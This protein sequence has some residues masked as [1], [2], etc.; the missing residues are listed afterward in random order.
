MSGPTSEALFLKA[1]DSF[2]ASLSPSEKQHLSGCKSI[3][4]VVDGIRK[5][6]HVNRAKRRTLPCLARVKSFGDQLRPYFDIL[7]R[8][9]DALPDWAN[10]ALGA[11]QLVLQ[12]ASHFVTFFEKLCITIE[13]IGSRLPRYQE[14]YDALC[15]TPSAISQ[16]LKSS[17]QKIY[18]SLFEFLTA[19]ARVFSTRDGKIK[20]SPRIVASLVWKPFELRFQK[21]LDEIALHKE[22]VRE[23]LQ[24]ASAGALRTVLMQDRQ[25]ARQRHAKLAEELEEQ[26]AR[27]DEQALRTFTASLN[28]WIDPPEYK[29]IV[30]DAFQEKIEGTAEW[31]FDTDIFASWREYEYEPGMHSPDALSP[32]IP[33]T[34]LWV[35]GEHYMPSHYSPDGSDTDDPQGKPGSGKTVLAASTI[36]ELGRPAVGD[37][38]FPP[39]VCY[40]FFNKNSSTRNSPVDAYRALAAQIFHRFHKLEKIHNVFA[41]AVSENMTSLTKASE[42]ELVDV[43]VQCLPHLPMLYFV[44]DGI[45]ECTDSRKLVAYVSDWC[46]A[47][48]LKVLFFSRPDVPS[49]LRA[50]PE[51]NRICLTGQHLDNDIARYL[52]LVMD[53]MIWQRLL[54]ANADRDQLIQNLVDRAEGMFLWVRLMVVFLNG[55]VM[56]KAERLETIMEAKAESLDQ[57][58]A[59][60]CRIRTRIDRLDARSKNLAYKA[61][62][63]TAYEVFS[64]HEL[65]EGICQDG[66]DMDDGA[67]TEQF[68]QMIILICC[69]LIEK[70]LNGRYKYIH[71]TALQF[72]LTGSPRQASISPLV[73][74]QVTS[75]ALMATRYVSF[76]ALQVPRKPLAGRI[77]QNAKAESVQERWPLLRFAAYRWI[78]FALDSIQ[79]LPEVSTIDEVD[80][81]ISTVSPYLKEGLGIMV[82]VEALYTLLGVNLRSTFQ[83]SRVKAI[84][85]LGSPCHPRVESF[86]SELQELL[87]DMINLDQAWG[88]T[89][90]Q[91]PSEIWGDVTVFTKSKFLVTTSAAMQESL[92]PRLEQAVDSPFTEPTKPIFSVAMSSSDASKL[93]VLSI[94][95]S[96]AFR[97]GWEN[98]TTIPCTQ[99][100]LKKQ[101][102]GK[103]RDSI[104]CGFSVLGGDPSPDIANA[105]LGWQATYELFLVQ[106]TASHSVHLVTISLDPMDVEICLRQNLRYT[107]LR[108]WKCT[109]PLSIAP[110][111]GH[112]SIL[113]R[114]VSFHSNRATYSSTNLPLNFD[115]R[116]RKAWSLDMNM[117][118]RYTYDVFWSADS[119]YLAFI[120]DNRLTAVSLAIFS[121]PTAGGAADPVSI[122]HVSAQSS[123]SGLISDCQFHPQEQLFLFRR[124][125]NV[126]LWHFSE[127]HSFPKLVHNLPPAPPR[128]DNDG[129]EICRSSNEYRVS[130]SHCGM[131][132]AIFNHGRPWPT[133]MPLS[134]FH[135]PACSPRKRMAI[136]AV[137]EQNEPRKRAILAR[138]QEGTHE[139]SLEQ[140]RMPPVISS[141]AVVCRTDDSTGASITILATKEMP[142]ELSLMRRDEEHEVNISVAKLPS[143]IPMGPVTATV[144]LPSSL[145]QSEGLGS[146]N[147]KVILAQKSALVYESD[148]APASTYLPLIIRKDARTLTITSSLDQGRE[149][150]KSMSPALSLP[151]R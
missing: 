115:P 147:C 39:E 113:S 58:D 88:I 62:M 16:E 72:A 74:P 77:G 42:N 110:D 136:E 143:Y 25:R 125:T 24:F 12:L 53:D 28:Q 93:A 55:P 73:P 126:Y 80:Q 31:L 104:E 151:Y 79:Q 17:L 99:E 135:S 142:G 108:R 101:K 69:G 81:M 114:I 122:N 144:S 107:P 120:D 26:H 118:S 82:W 7:E 109:F 102:A 30:E 71:L 134:D 49:L 127:D 149:N 47:S 34:L 64:S 54:P 98:N 18:C 123:W 70:G 65:R 97:L 128:L 11:L 117:S 133:L 19:V 13:S 20:R 112:C 87:A 27:N 89:L 56:T 1:R 150:I 41:V 138:S 86:L 75:K 67:S 59:M 83:E 36:F 15:S 2:L 44:L 68:D 103:S 57:L 145:S 8:F 32:R 85:M 146:A 3:A 137:V 23:E 40:F 141:T 37:T 95:P 46:M 10:I 91:T 132:L 9:C 4:D 130:F 140:T 148:E 100:I 111:L 106:D 116:L 14:V 94:F 29:Q 50:L 131:S 48:P 43:I 124:S 90:G 105:C 129:H 38:D 61:L 139:R 21:V 78:P 33:P 5:L 121:L 119:R 96:D 63:W 66:W 92:A 45:D 60:Y 6:E 35:H 52:E 51:E 76:L 22:I 84:E